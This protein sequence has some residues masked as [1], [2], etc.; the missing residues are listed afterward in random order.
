MYGRSWNIETCSPNS[1]A[2]G[3]RHDDPWQRCHAGTHSLHASLKIKGF[4]KHAPSRWKCT[5]LS[6]D[7]F[8]H[9]ILSWV[10]ES[11]RFCHQLHLGSSSALS[12]WVYSVDLSIHINQT[13]RVDNDVQSLVCAQHSYA[14][15]T[16]KLLQSLAA[17]PRV[18]QKLSFQGKKKNPNNKPQYF[19]PLNLSN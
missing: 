1:K 6:R 3:T 19:L 15:R 10:R 14:Q 18:T 7:L 9:A 4:L 2:Q 16:A 8:G 12:K 13:R 11:V 17:E 5:L